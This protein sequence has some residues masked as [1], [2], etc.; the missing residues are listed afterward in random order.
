MPREYEYAF[1]LHPT[2]IFITSKS[3]TD[4]VVKAIVF[5]MDWHTR[6][7][8]F[9]IDIISPLKL[10]ATPTNLHTCLLHLDDYLDALTPY[11]RYVD[12]R[13]KAHFRDT[14][15]MTVEE[16]TTYVDTYS[17]SRKK[18]LSK[19]RRREEPRGDKKPGE[20]VLKTRGHT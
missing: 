2:S 15:P 16:R 4:I 19:N 9:L 6:K 10:D 20:E 12:A 8:D 18:D 13:L 5:D 17:R 7:L 14:L 3:V 11:S 1:V